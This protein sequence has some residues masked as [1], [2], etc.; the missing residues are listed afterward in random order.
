MNKRLYAKLAFDGIRKNRQMYFPYITTCVAMVTMYYIMSFLQTSNA[1]DNSFGS[2]TI[3]MILGLGTWVI[4]IFSTIFLFYTNSFLIRRRKKE[5]GLYN[6]LGMG[7]RNIGAILF[8]E[9]L[10]VYFFSVVTGLLIGIAFSKMAELAL[11]RAIKGET[12]YK[13]TVSFHA[14]YMAVILF[15][16][17]FILLFINSIRQVRHSSAIAL[18]KSENVGEKPPKGN[19]IL[20]VLGLLFIVGGYFISV[21]IEN[22]IMAL[23]AF[24]A[25]VLLVIVGTY[26]LMIAGSVMFCKLLQKNKGY[27][28]KPEHF[29]SVSSMVYRM[30]RNGAGLASICILASMVLVMISSTTTLYTSSE[31]SLHLHYPRDINIRMKY[32]SLDKNNLDD[33]KSVRSEIEAVCRENGVEPLYA[34]SYSAANVTGQIQGTLVETDRSAIDEWTTVSFDD[35]AMFYFISADDYNRLSGSSV[36]L[37]DGE[38]LM[39]SNKSNY[40]GD[41]ISFNE[42]REFTI[43]DR[44]QKPKALTSNMEYLVPII[45]LVVPD[46]DSAVEGLDTL[47]DIS[48]IKRLSFES[49]YYFDTGKDNEAQVRLHS[50]LSEVAASEESYSKHTFSSIGI[51]DRESNREDFYSTFGGLFYLGIVLSFV[52]LIAAVLIIYY[53]QISEGYEDEKRFDIMQKVGMTKREIRRSINSQLLTVFFLPLILAGL[54]L[55]FAMPIVSKMLIMFGMANTKMFVITAAASFGVFTLFYAVV[56]KITSNAYYRIVSGV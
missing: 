8:F 33:I 34:V 24:F 9:T 15:G 36:T 2:G 18:L 28:Y 48:G 38:L 27:Y 4:A 13:I 45:Y 46:V 41:T 42:G 54:H 35:V 12:N 5:F 53:K 51:D 31:D 40:K 39:I 50:S 1:L 26:L 29:V 7:K 25:A 47:N 23:M 20:G 22:P 30:K 3:R 6:I 21:G 32:D 14:V 37:N 55:A 16:F 49:Y 56:Y 19:I 10:I 11:L 52:F 17:I 43:I 44:A